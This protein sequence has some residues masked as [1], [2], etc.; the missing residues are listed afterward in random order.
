MRDEPI[1]STLWSS[2]P[3][4]TIAITSATFGAAAGTCW[5]SD[6]FI[7]SMALRSRVFLIV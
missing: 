3:G 6:A 5:L 4:A 2:C 7:F 1:A